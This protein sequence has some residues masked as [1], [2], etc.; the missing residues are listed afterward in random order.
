MRLE[1]LFCLFNAQ[2]EYC[3]NAECPCPSSPCPFQ[4]VSHHH[5]P[6]QLSPSSSEL[7]RASSLRRCYHH[8]HAISD[9]AK[10]AR[11]ESRPA[12]YEHVEIIRAAD[13][14][15]SATDLSPLTAAWNRQMPYGIARCVSVTNER[16]CAVAFMN[17]MCTCWEIW[18]HFL[19]RHTPVTFW[20]ELH[21]RSL[22]SGS[23]VPPFR[24]KIM[25]RNAIKLTCF[26]TRSTPIRPLPRDD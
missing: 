10:T 18:S 21:P 4:S 19:I 13:E 24:V 11:R 22:N 5:C 23:T 1:K 25:L 2:C 6:T 20:R 26:L 12:R 3:R 7:G 17:F 16:K 15:S 14:I 9:R 8:S